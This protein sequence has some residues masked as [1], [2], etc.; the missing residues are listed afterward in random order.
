MEVERGKSEQ[1]NGDPLGCAK[2]GQR[3]GNRV[4]EGKGRVWRGNEGTN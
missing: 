4:Y 1:G 3:S 2:G